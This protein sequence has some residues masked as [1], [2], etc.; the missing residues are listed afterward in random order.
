MAKLPSRCKKYSVGK[1]I[2]GAVYVHRI[3][4]GL[5]PEPVKIASKY[6]PTDF[7]YTVVKFVEKESCVSFV[8][9]PDFDSAEEPV[10]G[11]ILRID[12]NGSH[13]RFRQQVDPFIYHHKWLFVMGDY[14]G[15]DVEKSKSR[16]ISWLG[17]EG[18]DMKRIGRKSY[19]DHHIAPRLI[20]SPERW[21]SSAEMQK[22]LQISSCELCHLR[23]MD[24][25]KFTKVGNAYFYQNVT[26]AS[27][28]KSVSDKK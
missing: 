26:E 7:D 22:E 11:E 20:D 8:V 17:L 12:S 25:L 19:W 5:L 13:R 14:H 3:Y 18:L 23:T 2:G 28:V 1:E 4:E 15:F 9:C 16:S 21:L 6:L 24:K 27:I 10:V